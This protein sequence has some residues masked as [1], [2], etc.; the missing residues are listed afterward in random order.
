MSVEP[1]L[2]SRMI[3]AY[4]KNPARFCLSAILPKS[5]DLRMSTAGEFQHSEFRICDKLPG[6]MPIQDMTQLLIAWGNGDQQAL[7]T[8][9]PLVEA[10]LHRLARRYLNGERP[11][12]TLQ[13]TALVNEAYLRLIDWKNVQ[14]QNRAH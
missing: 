9:V 13:A 8:L 10:E 12:H 11:G 1:L 4:W 3:P 5:T 14:W 2:Q 6:A 7:E